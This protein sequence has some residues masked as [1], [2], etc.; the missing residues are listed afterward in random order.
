MVAE[1]G[2]AKLRFNMK[3]RSLFAAVGLHL[4][5]LFA[6][7]GEPGLVLTYQPLDGQ[8]SG[9]VQICPVTAHDMFGHSGFPN[10]LTLIAAANIPPNNSNMEIDDHNVANRAGIKISLEE[11]EFGKMVVRLDL[12]GLDIDENFICTDKEIV[13]ATLEC[14]RRASGLKLDKM[15]IQVKTK[16]VGQDELKKLVATFVKHSKK[17]PFRWKVEEPAQ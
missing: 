15:K 10:E 9:E 5:T 8:G 12:T 17:K 16:P 14:M 6:T 13:G 4:G 3:L 7:A 1:G 11:D 2:T